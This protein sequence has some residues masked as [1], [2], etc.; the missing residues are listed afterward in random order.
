[1]ESSEYEKNLEQQEGKNGYRGK[2]TEK[3]EVRKNRQEMRKHDKRVSSEENLRLMF[4]KFIAFSER[5]ALG[6]EIEEVRKKD[7]GPNRS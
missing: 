4:E 5:E 6:L 7:R 3:N 1:M 2:G